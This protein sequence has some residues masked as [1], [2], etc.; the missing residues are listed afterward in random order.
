MS[1]PPRSL[2]G[3]WRDRRGVS[4]VEFALI[5]PVLVILYCGLAE[6]TQ[7]MMAQRR[8]SNIASSIGDLVAQSAQLSN[9][10]RDDVFTIGATIMAPFP[11][12]TLRM[13][14]VSVSSD[15]T[16]RDTVD[17]SEN[18]NSHANCP[19][20]GTV[21]GANVIPTGVLPA[22]QSVVMAKASYGYTSPIKFILPS[23]LNF[24]RTFYLRPRK[25][26]KVLRVT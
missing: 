10:R 13:C 22:N 3:F 25:S 16:G 19:A 1:K 24:Y 18:R 6:L 9:A 20:A 11:T 15:A 26:D 23:T 7:A 21:L 12:G 14:L 2:K 5:A 8:L 4:A 17:W